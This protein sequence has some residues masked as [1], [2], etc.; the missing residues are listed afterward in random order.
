MKK[1]Q[2]LQL[3]S[4]PS[5]LFSYATMPYS[6]AS[7]FALFAA[8]ALLAVGSPA[9][10]SGRAGR[11]GKAEARSLLRLKW[12]RSNSDCGSGSFEIPSFSS[13]P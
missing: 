3:L 13:A 2:P 12:R 9:Q 4:F 10:V 6:L 8:V 5:P 11:R 7:P 1:N